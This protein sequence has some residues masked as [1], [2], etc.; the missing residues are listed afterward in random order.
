MTTACTLALLIASVVST[1]LAHDDGKQDGKRSTA[2]GGHVVRFERPTDGFTLTG[3][4]IHGSRYGGGYDPTWTLARV[5]LFDES[6]RELERAFVPF[7]AWKVGRAEWVDVDLGPRRVPPAFFVAV[8]YFPTARRGI[9]QSIDEDGSG[10]SYGLSGDDLG[11]QLDGGEWM[12]RAVGSKKALK[13]ERPDLEQS[14]WVANGEGEV[15]GQRSIAGTGHAVLFKQPK[16]K[17]F[18][19]GF[20]LCGQRY[21]GGYDPETTHFHVV[22]C[23]KRLKPIL[24][25][26]FPYSRFGGSAMEWVDFEL[27]P[28]EI[29]KSFALLVYF[30]PTATQ[31]IYV[32]QWVEK[33]SASLTGLPGKVGGK[34]EK[35]KGWMIRARCAA[36]LGK[37]TLEE[38]GELPEED[39]EPGALEVAEM[40]SELDAAE[41][42]EDLGRARELSAALAAAGSDVGGC[43]F[44]QSRHFFLRSQG[45]DG[46]TRRALLA[47][48]E[49]AHTTP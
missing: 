5:R 28:V 46:E 17:P 34:A 13:V 38:P 41:V 33:K 9:Y 25:T 7:D 39:E 1:E 12:I 45:V 3:V 10:H 23:D 19:T 29:P 36:S 6:M 16:K 44:D 48:M 31:G 4:R 42:A 37:V 43:E 11:S 49:E 32:G 14:E 26:A 30:A 18:L 47:V 40:I 8:E 35:G 27:P 24:H 22:V 2:G 20:S 21:G 15:I